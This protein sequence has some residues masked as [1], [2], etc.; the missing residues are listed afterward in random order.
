MEKITTEMLKNF[1]TSS[2]STSITGE[3]ENIIVLTHKDFPFT[4][5][6]SIWSLTGKNTHG[7]YISN[8][9]ETVVGE[10]HGVSTYQLR[11]E[12]TYRVNSRRKSGDLKEVV[13]PNKIR[14][15]GAT[16]K[17]LEK[18]YTEWFTFLNTVEYLPFIE[19]LKK[20]NDIKNIHDVRISQVIANCEN[21]IIRDKNEWNSNSDL[22]TTLDNHLCQ[23]KY[24]D[25]SDRIS[26]DVKTYRLNDKDMEKLFIFLDEMSAGR[27]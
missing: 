19:E 14:A 12:A 8:E 2:V 22:D 27:K 24:S 5:K 13:Q 18:F 16:E 17:R 25:T 4:C 23:L 11:R 15:M 20:Q 10:A 9:V 3:Y 7:M 21:S 6:I 1:T 26:I